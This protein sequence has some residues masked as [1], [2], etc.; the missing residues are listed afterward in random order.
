[1]PSWV[2]LVALAIVSWLAVAVV[3]GLLLGRLLD[4]VSKRPLFARRR[5]R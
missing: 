4:V 1:M 5:S 3:G 2:V